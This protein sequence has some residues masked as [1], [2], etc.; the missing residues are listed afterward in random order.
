MSLWGLKTH[1]TIIHHIIH[2]FQE[3]QIQMLLKYLLNV[4][5]INL[6]QFNDIVH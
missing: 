5:E 2:A 6:E 3:T 4:C 1:I